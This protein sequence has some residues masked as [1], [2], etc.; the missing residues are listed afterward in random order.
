MHQANG[1]GQRINHN[2][3]NSIN[4]NS[5]GSKVNGGQDP[6]QMS[7]KRV[8]VNNIRSTA[9]SAP[10]DSMEISL[11]RNAATNL[12]TPRTEKRRISDNKTCNSHAT[13]TSR[14]GHDIISGNGER[15]L[16][17]NPGMEFQ[18]QEDGED[19]ERYLIDNPAGQFLTQEMQVI[20]HPPRQR[21][22][23]MK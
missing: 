17:P 9:G 10:V 6:D 21:D 18:M 7:G 11:L 14:S 12:Q 16:I 20:N 23:I 4:R 8:A 22:P 3:M 5:H 15:G 19:V 1:Q 2:T 13:H